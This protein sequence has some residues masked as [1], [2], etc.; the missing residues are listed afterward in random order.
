MHA[1]D[2]MTMMGDDNYAIRQRAATGAA[3][4]LIKSRPEVHAQK[5]PEVNASP[6]RNAHLMCGGWLHDWISDVIRV[7]VVL[8]RPD[9]RVVE[10]H[11][12]VQTGRISRQSVGNQVTLVHP[13]WVGFLPPY[14]TSIL[15]CYLFLDLSP[16]VMHLSH[17]QISPSIWEIRHCNR[18]PQ[19]AVLLFVAKE[20]GEGMCL[21]I[22][23]PRCRLVY[24]TD[25]LN[26]IS[27]SH[28]VMSVSPMMLLIVE[29]AY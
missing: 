14:V 27:H 3:T 15:H 24:G 13:T 10:P 6:H 19:R 2:Q 11:A 4:L 26:S 22:S 25:S 29:S 17:S 8:L 9:T 1:D 23:N 12:T 18:S 7:R 5:S 20:E 28:C 16:C 21:R